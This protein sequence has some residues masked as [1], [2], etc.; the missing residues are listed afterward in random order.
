MRHLTIKK[1]WFLTIIPLGIGAFCLL[2]AACVEPVP[3]YGTWADND[4]NTFSF[5]EDGTFI[6]R[7]DGD[8]YDGNYS[9][10]MNALT[11]SANQDFRMVT[12]WDIRGN[13]LYFTWTNEDKINSV[14]TLYKI[15]N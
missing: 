8:T 1:C 14:M 10:Q 6:A 3:L 15:S 12:E 4:G 9:I 5:F 13:M 7:V 2:Y 11:I